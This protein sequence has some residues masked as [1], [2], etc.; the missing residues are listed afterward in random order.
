MF[1]YDPLTTVGAL[2][3]LGA[4]VLGLGLLAQKNI[5]QLVGPILIGGFTW[6]AT[7]LTSSS[8]VGVTTSVVS[9]VLAL[10]TSVV[11]AF[12]GSLGI[13]LPVVPL[14]LIIA[15][16]FLLRRGKGKK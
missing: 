14:V 1:G 8:F 11:A 10:A 12:T 6:Q 13:D 7:G 5:V 16:V 3:V 9:T 4:L 2:V 15:A